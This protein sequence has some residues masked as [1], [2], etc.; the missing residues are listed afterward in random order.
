MFSQAGGLNVIAPTF[1]VQPFFHLVENGADAVKAQEVCT[2]CDRR[3]QMQE[4]INNL[5]PARAR[6]PEQGTNRPVDG[7]E[8]FYRDVI[9]EREWSR[10]KPADRI[11]QSTFDIDILR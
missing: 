11:T 2:G 10:E 6:R 1:H 4:R 9:H 7:R 8:Q 3:S 5:P